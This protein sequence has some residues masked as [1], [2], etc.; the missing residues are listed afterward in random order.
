NILIV[1][2]SDVLHP[3]SRSLALRLRQSS[4]HRSWR[5]QLPACR[6][7][8]ADIELRVPTMELRHL[9]YFAAVAQEGSLTK[10]AAR[11]GIQQPPLG[12]QV[13][14]LETELGVRLFDRAAKRIALNASGKV[15][16]Q[17]ALRLLAEADEMVEHVRRFDKGERGRLIV[18]FTS[19]ASMHHL[20]PQ[21]LRAFRQAYPLARIEVQE[22]E[23]Y[24]LILALEQ[25]RI[26]AAFLHIS[27]DR[28]PGLRSRALAQ[29]GMVVAV[30]ADHPLAKE[31]RKPV[32]LS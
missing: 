17:A 24:E 13:R 23:T 14:S 26:D 8:D 4:R 31:P 16:L 28:F 5:K 10:A 29:E 11:L 27:T 30:P 32:T 21:I 25:R 22:S 15:F 1:Y 19:S 7:V 3:R 6:A 9:R 12:Q 2:Y 18:G 20:A